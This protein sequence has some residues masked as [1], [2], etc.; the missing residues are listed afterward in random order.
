MIRKFYEADEGNWGSYWKDEGLNKKKQD[1]ID[2]ILANTPN[3]GQEKVE[4][5][6]R[7]MI[8]VIKAQNAHMKIDTTTYDYSKLTV[9][10]IESG[11][12]MTWGNAGPFNPPR[13][14]IADFFPGE[15]TF[16]DVK[17]KYKDNQE[18]FTY[19]HALEKYISH[20]E[21]KSE[22]NK[23]PGEDGY[24]WSFKI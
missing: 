16:R 20:L 7:N 21:G 8:N 22:D 12:K 10:D 6:G 14:N 13:P 4:F 2:D 17:E 11:M 3:F 1:L 15:T 23:F 5:T 18:I 19:I 24:N 9:A